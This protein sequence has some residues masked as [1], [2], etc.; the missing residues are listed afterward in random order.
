MK[1]VG[2]NGSGRPGGNTAVLVREVL[3]GA[4][5]HGAETTYIELSEMNIGVCTVCMACK[6]SH[7]CVLQDNMQTFYDLASEADLL[8]LGTPIYLDHVSSRMMNFIQRLYCY[9][10]P[11]IENCYPRVGVKAVLG[12]T[13]GAGKPD[14]YQGV[15]D[16]M[17]GRLKGYWD[18]ETAGM[19]TVPQTCRDEVI[20]A[21][22]AE[23]VRGRELGRTLCRA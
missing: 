3:D 22:H 15:L 12:I 19:L 7:R 9:V 10:G 21:D 14:M 1:V 13:Y 11:A 17:A 18:I 23:V 8:V 16:W 5:E 20:A 6:T 4:A 2:I